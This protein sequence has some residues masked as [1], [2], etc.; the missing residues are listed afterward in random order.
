MSTVAGEERTALAKA[1][2]IEPEKLSRMVEADL[3]WIV[4]KAIEKDRT[5][6]YETANGLARD[7]ERFLGDEPVS[8]RP[9]SAGYQLQ[10]YARRHKAALRVAAAIAAV[11][12]A[13]T[14]VSLWLAVRATDAEKKTAATLKEVT[15]ERD[16]K[17]LARKDAEAIS[18]FFG[19]VFQSPD[20]AQIGRAH[21]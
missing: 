5:R 18:K 11:L 9:P 2:K 20:P 14:I 19:E 12:V 15:N 21:V 1:H 3:D 10:K 13:A 16:A 6:R 8:A 4:M 17:E 7:I